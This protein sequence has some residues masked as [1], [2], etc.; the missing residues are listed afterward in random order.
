MNGLLGE[1]PHAPAISENSVSLNEPPFVTKTANTNVTA[2]NIL[3]N[4]I[5]EFTA[6]SEHRLWY[7][8]TSD[9][10][11]KIECALLATICDT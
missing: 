7:T 9:L 4:N 8:E 5:F 1:Q 2:T 3:L 10:I 11:L 6:T